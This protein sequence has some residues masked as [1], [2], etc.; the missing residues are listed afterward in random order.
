[1]LRPA[2]HYPVIITLYTFHFNDKEVNP[3]INKKCNQREQAWIFNSWAWSVK[4]FFWCYKLDELELMSWD[5][6][7]WVVFLLPFLDYGFSFHGDKIN[8][9]IS[10]WGYREKYTRERRRESG[11][12]CHSL[13]RSRAACFACP[14]RR[15]CSQASKLFVIEQ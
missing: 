9:P 3:L 13:A 2:I 8:N 6:A 5:I 4:V 15:A 7:K 12:L 11:G 1:M 10:I 14:N